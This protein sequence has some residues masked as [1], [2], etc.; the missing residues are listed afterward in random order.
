MALQVALSQA[1]YDDNIELE[2]I[3]GDSTGSSGY[4]TPPERPSTPNTQIS[5]IPSVFARLPPQV[6]VLYHQPLGLAP[7]TCLPPWNMIMKY[8]KF[9]A[10]FAVA[11]VVVPPAF[12]GMSDG[13]KSARLA[14]WGAMVTYRQACLNATSVTSQ[15]EEL[16]S[17][18][19]DPPPDVDLLNLNKR[20]MVAREVQGDHKFQPQSH[21]VLESV[22]A[23]YVVSIAFLALF[24]GRRCVTVLT[25]LLQLVV[26]VTLATVPGLK[27]SSRNRRMQR[28]KRLLVSL[29]DSSDFTSLLITPET[30]LPIT[31]QEIRGDSSAIDSGAQVSNL[32]R[33]A[34]RGSSRTFTLLEAAS[35]G[36]T[37]AV[38]EQLSLG[39]NPNTYYG[40]WPNYP[41]LAAVRG[42]HLATV[43]LL[44]HS[45]ANPDTS[46]EF[47]L[48]RQQQQVLRFQKVEADDEL[49][50]VRLNRLYSTY[51]RGDRQQ[52][53][54]LESSESETA[55]HIAVGLDQECIA[56]AL[57]VAGANVESLR[58]DGQ[59]PLHIASL[60]GSTRSA[61]TLLVHGADPNMVDR[62]LQTPLHVA[63]QER[64]DIL[65]GHLIW[66]GANT[67]AKNYNGVT[68]LMIVCH[69]YIDMT[70]EIQRWLVESP[71]QTCGGQSND[72]IINRNQPE[73]KVDPENVLRGA[74]EDSLLGEETSEDPN[75]SSRSRLSSSVTSSDCDLEPILHLLVRG[76]ANVDVVD[77]QGQSLLHMAAIGAHFALVDFLISKGANVNIQD[78]NGQTPLHHA[79]R[80]RDIAVAKLLLG[81]KTDTEILSHNGKTALHIAVEFGHIP[82]VRLLLLYGANIDAPFRS[83]SLIM[84]L[85]TSR[86]WTDIASYLLDSGSTLQLGWPGMKSPLYIAVEKG[87]RGLVEFLLKHGAP[88]RL[89]QITKSNDPQMSYTPLGQAIASD[90]VDIARLLTQHGE[91]V[92][93]VLRNG[94]TY[95]WNCMSRNPLASA[96]MIDFLLAEGVDV[97]KKNHDGETVIYAARAK[98]FPEFAEYLE[99]LNAGKEKID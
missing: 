28:L 92:R 21:W 57:I 1:A 19:L 17:R 69:R 84:E 81:A 9:V 60:E 52:T 89:G 43:Q 64:H 7:M 59:T 50:R 16:L 62:D 61:D 76:G 24:H 99:G 33:L 23:I 96:H 41:L 36:S 79:C 5:Q 4:M 46:T 10:L 74:P 95:L 86:G 14:E 30:I 37:T 42:N 63:L 2:S 54:Y 88:P 97:N 83:R 6:M 82:L 31:A 75:T 13:R 77:Q 94:G 29:G 32:R 58:S 22:Y 40:I 93:S 70:I 3:S 67:N 25:S 65:A 47:S 15:C 85:A 55:L 73:L 98:G 27:S 34:N 35:A 68:P 66:A 11:V 8:M 87:N 26:Y 45:G 38:Q 49:L 71:A 44:L 72:S 80:I 48:T 20:F 18:P 78:M 56:N 91:N 53:S 90:N 51:W 12:S 39:K